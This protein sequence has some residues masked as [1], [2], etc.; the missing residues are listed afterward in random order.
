MANF[1]KR[2]EVSGTRHFQINPG[3]K[4]YD[5]STAT[6]M[7]MKEKV[8]TC[9]LLRNKLRGMVVKQNKDFLSQFPNLSFLNPTLLE[10]G[11]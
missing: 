8:F 10:V 2:L 3:P 5:S 6:S 9:L 4:K 11:Y 7:T 1:G